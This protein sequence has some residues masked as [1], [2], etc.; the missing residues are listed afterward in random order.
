MS[1]E[2]GKQAPT[3]QGSRVA[4]V[5]RK[6]RCCFHPKT[7]PPTRQPSQLCRVGCAVRACQRGKKVFNSTLLKTQH[8]GKSTTS[9]KFA[10]W[11]REDELGA[12][13][14]LATIEL[15]EAMRERGFR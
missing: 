2:D 1:A 10:T 5:K 8:K 14:R 13:G 12:A 15:Q 4:L 9:K 3:P 11:T 6:W 7:Q